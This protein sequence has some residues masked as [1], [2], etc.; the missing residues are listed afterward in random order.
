ML[1]S[2][3]W[4]RECPQAV[5]VASVVPSARVYRPPSSVVTRTLAGTGPDG[6]ETGPPLGVI[7]ELGARDGLLW[8]E[9]VV[10]RPAPPVRAAAARN[11]PD[12]AARRGRTAS[13]NDS[14]VAGG[15]VQPVR[16]RVRDG[17][18]VLDA[19]AEPSLKVDPGL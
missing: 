4:R 10:A 17:H 7:V 9:G 16:S 5:R 13:G 12:A 18:G 3:C 15:A 8:A 2:F 14:Q 6:R 19:F 11:R 1:G